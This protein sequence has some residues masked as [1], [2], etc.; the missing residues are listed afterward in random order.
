[1][2]E[3]GELVMTERVDTFCNKIIVNR[4]D[5]NITFMALGVAAAWSLVEVGH[6]VWLHDSSR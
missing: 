5:H 1:M 3:S 6:Y 2:K 4:P